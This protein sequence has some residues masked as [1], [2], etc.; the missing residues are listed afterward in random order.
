MDEQHRAAWTSI[1]Q[2][3][4][5][6]EHTKINHKSYRMILYKFC[7]NLTLDETARFCGER[8][9]K[10]AVRQRIKKVLKRLRKKVSKQLLL[11]IDNN[12]ICLLF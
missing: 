3:A 8:I 2:V 4:C 5:I 7:N 1:Y 12:K 11:D 9:T 10:E 6:L